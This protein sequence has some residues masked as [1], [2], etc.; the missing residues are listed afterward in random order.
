[1]KYVY[2]QRP[3]DLR[4]TTVGYN[5]DSSG[6]A[7]HRMARKTAD[8]WSWKAVVA[9]LPSLM[10]VGIPVNFVGISDSIAAQLTGALI[11]A[12]AIPFIVF[13]LARGG[14]FNTFENLLLLMITLVVTVTVI[15]TTFIFPY[16]VSEWLPALYALTP[17]L[18]SF[19]FRLL[20]I[21][22]IDIVRGMMIAAAFVSVLVLID[23]IS[24]M[25]ALDGYGR[26]S[27]FG[28][29]GSRRLVIMKTETAIGCCL[30]FV[31]LID[32][33]R[34][35]QRLLALAGFL[36]T[37]AYLSIVAESRLLMLAIILSLIVYV[38]FIVNWNKKI[39]IILI[40][41]IGLSAIYP[42]FIQKYV[43]AFL[44][45]D[46]YIERDA[47]YT[48]RVLE[49]N[50]YSQY[51]DKTS[52]I[53]FGLLSQSPDKANFVAFATNHGGALYG[54][55]N[56]NLY[57]ADT[58]IW[59]ALFQFGY[60]GITF[61]TILTC[62]AALKLLWLGRRGSAPLRHELGIAG[63]LMLFLFASPW[64]INFFTLQWSCMP[65]AIFCS[66]LVIGLYEEENLKKG[67]Q[68]HPQSL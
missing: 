24:P 5:S 35:Y 36:I 28:G 59:G 53:G 66:L 25:G 22:V 61:V 40:G 8:G 54:V 57:L 19:S 62:A 46:L 31:K 4:Y 7:T 6:G 9:G 26:L 10:W 38:L 60:I 39:A 17:L 18:L 58:G 65:G 42:V 23:R 2:Q 44:G 43:D 14:R 20:N 15:S 37:L 55:S 16:G 67:L 12:T 11:V 41:A 45:N 47:S 50:Y 21:R 64:P 49:L 27:S 34:I 3:G 48:W 52:G 13:T 32:E 51:Y 29:L 33:K 1:M 68:T 63:A 30:F 56:Y